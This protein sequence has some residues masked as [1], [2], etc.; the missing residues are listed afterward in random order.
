MRFLGICQVLRR[1]GGGYGILWQIGVDKGMTGRE[2]AECPDACGSW[3]QGMATERTEAGDRDP[4]TRL[5]TFWL[6]HRTSSFFPIP[7]KLV[8]FFC[9]E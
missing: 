6:Q 8:N 2:G 3:T 1:F 7:S 4:N 5:L 9:R